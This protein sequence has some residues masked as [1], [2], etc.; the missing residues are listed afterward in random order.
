MTKPELIYRLA[1]KLL[2]LPANDVELA[3]NTL[4]EHLGS[5]LASGE[6]IHVRGFGC[7]SKRHRPARLARNPGTGNPVALAARYA[8]HFKPGTELRERVNSARR[9]GVDSVPLVTGN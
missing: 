4:I 9:V 6:R 1:D 7:F 3:V 5:T 8:V 2:H